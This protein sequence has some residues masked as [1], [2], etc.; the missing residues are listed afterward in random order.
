M[1]DCSEMFELVKETAK[2]KCPQVPYMLWIKDLSCKTLTH[3]CA[4]LTVKA[5]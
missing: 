3:E 5:I 4:T 2:V 1:D